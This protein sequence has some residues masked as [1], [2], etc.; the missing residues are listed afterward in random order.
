LPATNFRW[1]EK[2]LRKEIKTYKKRRDIKLNLR[3]GWRGKGRNGQ[4]KGVERY[5]KNP[6]ITE[7]LKGSGKR[8]GNCTKCIPESKIIF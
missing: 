4:E 7:I 8:L 5:N 3:L 2:K 6:Y 1:R